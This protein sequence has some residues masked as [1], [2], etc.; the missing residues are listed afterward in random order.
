M[1]GTK[2]PG[3]PPIKPTDHIDAAIRHLLALK[4]G[5]DV[6]TDS[7]IP[8]AAHVM[9]GMSIVLDAAACGT[10]VDD[11]TNPRS[12]ALARVQAQIPERRAQ[13]LNQAVA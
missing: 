11:R 12:D 10:L 8:H 3:G 9:A 6:A 1:P 5:E 4:E 7:Q 2:V 13:V